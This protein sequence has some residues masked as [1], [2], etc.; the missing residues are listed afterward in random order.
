MTSTIPSP[1]HD[2][3]LFL[4]SSPHLH[5]LPVPFILFL[6]PSVADHVPRHLCIADLMGSRGKGVQLWR[7]TLSTSTLGA[8][9][10][11]SPAKR[12]HTQAN[13]GTGA[14]PIL[15]KFNLF[16]ITLVVKG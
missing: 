4:S 5:T 16:L 9:F 11:P 15:P 8:T 2:L 3:F 7:E 6:C 12:C 14:V 10:H 13:A 1:H